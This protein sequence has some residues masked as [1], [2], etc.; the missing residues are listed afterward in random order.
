MG[1]GVDAFQSVDLEADANRQRAWRERGQGAV[2]KAAAIAQ[3]VAGSVKAI[4]R[5]QDQLRL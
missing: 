3:P 5:Q 1:F 2:K 4:E